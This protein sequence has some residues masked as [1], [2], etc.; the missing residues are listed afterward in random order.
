[1]G[2]L[3]A[4]GAQASEMELGWP[5]QALKVRGE[6]GVFFTVVKNTGLGVKRPKFGFCSITS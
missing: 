2:N 6:M 5:E 3:G 1:M 4:V